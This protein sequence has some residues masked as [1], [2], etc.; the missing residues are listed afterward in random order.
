VE[1]AMKSKLIITCA[2][3]G[4]LGSTVA[5]A[6]DEEATTVNAESAG[7]Q[8]ENDNGQDSAAKSAKSDDS[9][10]DRIADANARAA[11]ARQQGGRASLTNADCFPKSV[12][13]SAPANAKL[14]VSFANSDP[15]MLFPK[16]DYDRMPE[17]CKPLVPPKCR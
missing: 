13:N 7:P 10:S 14:C 8:S 5:C 2:C 9:P 16:S 15:D 4:I 6:A 11:K 3:L 12:P 1:I 17:D